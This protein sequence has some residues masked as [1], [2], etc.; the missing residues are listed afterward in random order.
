MPNRPDSERVS[1]QDRW[2]GVEPPLAQRLHHQRDMHIAHSRIGVI[3]RLM[4]ASVIA[5]GVMFAQ[6]ARAQ[7]SDTWEV[8]VAPFY[9]WASKIDGD[10]TTRSATIPVFL[11]FADAVDNLAGTFSAHVEAR[12]GKWGLFTDVDFVRLSSDSQFTIEGPLASRTI[13]GSF[14]FDNTIF[15]AGG[16]YQ[17]NEA[18]PF[19]VIGGLRTLSVSPKVEFRTPT[20]ELTPIDASRTV[21]SGFAGFTYRPL[22]AARWR[23][24]SRADIGGGSAFSWSATVGAE[25]RPTRLLGLVAGYRALGVNAGSA[26]DDHVVREFEMTYYGPIFGFNLHWGGQ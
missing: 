6:P 11:S 17:P 20:E 19:A 13:E 7:Q 22:L 12:K 21:A 4:A 15:E 1:L 25:F 16:S 26:D 14:E 23:L 3:A 18:V 5:S 8:T 24:L 2:I 10:F 9:F